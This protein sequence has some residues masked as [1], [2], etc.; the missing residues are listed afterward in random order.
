MET[1]PKLY[2]LE[3]VSNWERT[4]KKIHVYQYCGKQFD[5][6]EHFKEHY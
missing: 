2:H 6:F 1:A 3:E 5:H 4:R